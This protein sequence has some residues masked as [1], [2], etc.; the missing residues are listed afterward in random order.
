MKVMPM[1]LRFLLGRS[2]SGKTTTC[3][4]EIRDKL[5][6]DP[7]GNPIVYLVPEQMTFQSE[8]ALIHTPGLA[9]MMRAQV[10]SFTRLAWR[11]LQE[12]GGMS[13]YHINE[14]GMQMMIRKIVEHRK[15]Q[16]KLFGRAVDKAGFIQQLH[17]MITECKRYCVAPQHLREHVKFLEE[18]GKRPAEKVLADKL[19]DISIVYE[20][21]ER[22]LLNHYI[23]SEDYLRLLAEKIPHSRYLR[24]AEIYID[25]FHQFTPQE[26]MVL[27]QLLIHCKRVTVSLTVD[28]PYDDWLPNELHLFY[29]TAKTYHDI[30]QMALANGIA[31]EDAIIL[32]KNMRH[33]EGALAHLEAHYHARPA[34]A[35]PEKTDSIIVY[36]AANRRAEVEAIA[37]EIVRLVRDEGYRYR[38]IA[39]I[40]RNTEDYRDLV[41]TIFSDFHIPYFMDEKESMHHHPLIELLRASMEIITSRWRYE[42]VFRAIKTDLL[43]PVGEDTATLREAMDRLENYV[44]AYGIKG[45][46]WTNGE[47]W[48]YRRYQALEGLSVPQTDEEKQYEEKLNQW[49][50]MIA[51]PLSKLER[52]MRRAKDGRSLCEAIY[53]FLEELQIPRKLEKMSKEAEEQGRL[54]EARQHEQ[55]WNAVIDLFNQYVDMLGSEPVPLAE[56]AK[57]IET[58]LDRLEFSLVPPAIDQ[59]IIAQLDRSRLIDVK[60]AFIVGVNEGVIPAKAKE[61]GLLAETEREILQ[62]FGTRVAPG[63][64]EQLFYEPFFIYLALTCPSER[65]YVTYPLANEEGKA[66]SPSLIIKQLADLFPNLQKHVCG[67]DPLDAEHAEQ[68]AF[69]TVP[70]ATLTYLVAQLQAWKRHYSI[71]PL[72]WDVYNF[73][74]SDPQWRKQARKAIAGLFYT[75]AATPLKKEISKRLYGKKIQASVSRMEQFQKCPFSHFVSHGLRLKERDVFRLD[76][77]DIGQLFHYALKI[78]SDRLREAKI[79]WRY[80]SKQ[81]CEQL[82]AEAVEQIAPLIQQQ[83]LL[84]S[85]RYHYMKRKLQN[86]V[87]RTTNVLSEHAKASGFVPIG[88]ELEFG[89]NGALPPLTFRLPDGTVMEL[90]G[91]IDRVDKAESSRGV[92]LRVIDYKSSAKTLNLAEVYYGL[93]LQILTYLDIVLT[94]AE[95]LVGKEA[96][97]AGILYFHVHNPIIKSDQ[98]LHDEKEAERKLLEQFKM[99]G[100][101]LG[102]V[103]AIRLMDT[104]MEEGKWS[105]IV[106]AQITKKGAIHA[107]SSVVSEENFWH[108][109][110]HIRHLFQMIGMQIIDG[111]VDVAPYK[112]KE[113]TPCEFCAFKPVCQF[114][115]SF[116]NNRY[117]LLVPQENHEIVQKLSE[118]KDF[119]E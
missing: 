99:R 1:S 12:T 102:D 48:T 70:R 17:D 103:E 112:L 8:Y 76:A 28:A 36:E 64:R 63:G 100:L 82:S 45:E 106:P 117:R 79:D 97:P 107:K 87:A 108:L 104:Q 50:D 27:E 16:L 38:D 52:R 80:L 23:H 26:Y 2:G 92:L 84:S 54:M 13:R 69:I 119:D 41:K 81:Q 65:L 77:P 30:R 72:W 49:R 85:N 25:G 95:Q 68:Q 96:F 59:V 111:I 37:R 42:S 67:N 46:K 29:L 5:K 90:V 93:A 113:Q 94:Y 78:I 71:A 86:V 7:K 118:G 47:R 88:L 9:G 10:F 114:D 35:F 105:L 53:L 101:L 57:I 62:Q 24:N 116:P 21:L 6:E 56:F 109:R 51:A 60:C 43:F 22:S 58:G 66:L 91:R 3:L 73:Y 44:L 115:E 39:L 74:A 15:Q 32:E 83:V 14:I 19:N 110:R 75:N 61:D 34:V 33:Q 11:V 98:L 89:P 55:V 4:N 40:V 20:E 31:L 18:Q